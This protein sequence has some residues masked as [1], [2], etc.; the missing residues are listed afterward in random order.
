MDKNPQKRTLC[1]VRFF[2]S[3]LQKNRLFKNPFYVFSTSSHLVRFF[4]STI[5]REPKIRGFHSVVAFFI[6]L[7]FIFKSAFN[8]LVPKPL[9][10]FLQYIVFNMLRCHWDKWKCAWV[11]N[12]PER[13]FF[14]FDP[15]CIF[16]R[17]K[18][19][20]YTSMS[21]VVKYQFRVYKIR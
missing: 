1:I 4:N 19:P 5:P 12:G 7:D 16:S 8:V 10:Y 11:I 21:L 3:F 6:N 14:Y 18:M 20:I 15:S 9:F 17:K 13:F 2:A